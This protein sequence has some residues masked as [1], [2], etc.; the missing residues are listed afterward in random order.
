MFLWECFYTIHKK[1]HYVFVCSC[2]FLQLIGLALLLLVSEC[3]CYCWLHVEKS[4]YCFLQEFD[5]VEVNLLEYLTAQPSGTSDSLSTIR[6][7][8]VTSGEVMHVTVCKV[9]LY[10]MHHL[11]CSGIM[12]HYVFPEFHIF[13][14]S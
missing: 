1:Q 10:F 6:D 7:W 4:L 5:Y 12:I 13:S 2:M 9:Y 11:F 8:S 14:K 3:V